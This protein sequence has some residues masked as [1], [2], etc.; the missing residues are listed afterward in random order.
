MRE[1]HEIVTA[2]MI[3]LKQALLRSIPVCFVLGCSMELFMIKTG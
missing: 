3:I 1:S 2:V